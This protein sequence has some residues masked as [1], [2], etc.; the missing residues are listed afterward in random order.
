MRRPIKTV[1]RDGKAV[2]LEDDASGTFELAHWSVEAR[3]WVRENGE[4]SKITPTYWHATRRDEYLL[5]EGDEFL[6]QKEIGSSGPSAP[7]ER[8]TLPFPPGRAA[9]QLTPAA[10][11][12]I[13]LREVAKADPFTV[14]RLEARAA[15]GKA[16]RGPS[17]RRQFAVS[18]IAAVMVAA[19]LVG[20]YFRA[21]IAGYVTRYAGQQDSARTGTAGVQ[22]VEQETRIPG[23]DSRPDAAQTRQG[24]EPV[25]PEA[26]RRRAEALASELAKA[27]Q[28][29]ET[30]VALASKTRD[31]AAQLKQAAESTMAELRQSLQKEH[32]RAEALASEL[33]RA[34]RDIETQAAL[35]SKTRDEAAQLK[36]AAKSPTAELRQSLQKEHDRAE[37]LAGELAKARRDVEAQAALSGKMGAAAAQLK[38]AADSAKA[39]LQQSLQK[40]HDRAEALA[41][42][43]AGA[44]RD[45]E[46]QVALASK[47]GDEAT[48]LKQLKQAAESA[49]AELRQSL[50]KE[51]DRAEALTGELAK[52]RRDIEAQV[53]LASKTGAEA[54]QLKQAAETAKTD[55]QQS[56]QKEHDRAEAL[57]GK[58]AGAQRDIETQAALASKTYAELAQLTQLKQAAEG[59]AAE[60][61]QSLQKEHDRAEGLASEL[62]KARSDMQTQAAL[63]SKTGD[64]ATQLTQVKQAAESAAAELRQS[65]QKEHDRAEALASELASAQRDIEAALASKTGD[66]ATQLKQFKQAAESAAAELRQ[67]LQKEH[68]RAEALASELASAQRDIKTQA[69]LASKTGDEATQLKQF[70]QAAESAA[71][72]LRQSL[73]KEHDR[74]EALASE[75]ASAQQDI[76]AQAALASKAGDEA[77]QLKQFK[78]AAE[79]ATAELRKSQQK[80]HDRAE[81]LVG[82][83]AKARSDMQTQAAL[84]SKAGDEAAQLKQAAESAKTELQQSLQK[85]H[86]KAEALAGELA[87]ARRDIETQAA[88]ASKAGDEAAQLKQAAESAKTELRASLQQERD[89]AEA[90]A[91][92]RESTQPTIGARMAVERA[93]NSP[94]SQATQVAEA[95]ATEQPAAAEAQGS[96]EA[97]RLLARASALLAQGNI[98]AARIVLERAVE[99]GSAQASFMLAETYDPLV[100]STWKTYG[101]R[102]DATK[103]RELYAKAQAG[104]IQ[105]AKDRSDALH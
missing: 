53:A 105:E 17:T 24:A 69:A 73:Q 4:L 46:T 57:A 92:G 3:A 81:A 29:V 52:A 58:L 1:P 85:E 71:A 45:V 39:E 48:Q 72:D 62:A 7:R 32:D 59:A 30:Q 91:P 65:L 76:K 102:G 6:L 103:A 38:Q 42:E 80:E 74:A 27:Q 82:E 41:G 95:P 104:G 79:S 99:T 60:L 13:A 83:L 23:Q 101:T 70:K 75:L 90:L 49:A 25:R 28:D 96:P 26:E 77:A 87:S 11:D 14:A 93:S 10:G 78:Q 36:Q 22:V 20:W 15:P 8:R 89:R 44:Q 43:L 12:N 100:L 2:I 54:A 66:E 55:L 98:G 40:E 88:L 35:P 56:L 37:A 86:D 9:P 67:S 94:V 47:A 16:E 19:L 61:R 51:H 63:A 18:S 97:A 5:Q 64:E 21:E 84:S 68:D 31:Q 33:A 50:Q 34:R